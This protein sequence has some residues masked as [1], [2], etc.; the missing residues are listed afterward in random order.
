MT[1]R[2]SVLRY[3]ESESMENLSRRSALLAGFAAALSPRLLHAAKV[4]RPAP[5]LVIARPG[6]EQIRL[7]Q[8]RGKIVML[9]LLLTTCPHCQRCARTIQQVLGDY[10]AKGVEALGAAINDEA[11]FDLL[12][13]EMAA[14]AKFPMGIA[15]RDK[16]YA[17]LQA[18]MNAG[19]VYFPQ[20]ALID[21]HGIIRAQYDGTDR[22]FENEE[23]NLRAMLDTLL[24]TSAPSASAGQK[25]MAK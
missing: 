1:G 8:Y 17:F 25:R 21:R 11:R 3:I 14:G 19:P 12:R 7:S 9:E 2:Q 6:G 18:E 22:F 23:T 15:D 24:K 16:A 4:P 10:K 20:L 5:E 13:F